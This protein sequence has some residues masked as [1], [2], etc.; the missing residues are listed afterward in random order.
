MKRAQCYMQIVQTSSG[1][2]ICCAQSVSV[3][4]GRASPEAWQ[5]FTDLRLE[6]PK[7]GEKA[8]CCVPRIWIAE[9]LLGT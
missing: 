2:G 7:H 6:F 1:G 9:G 5:A 3:N 8:N 4:L